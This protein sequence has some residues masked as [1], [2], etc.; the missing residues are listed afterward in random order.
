MCSVG[1]TQKKRRAATLRKRRTTS[2]QGMEV[3]DYKS[4]KKLSS[5]PSG[6]SDSAGWREPLS[7]GHAHATKRLQFVKHLA[8]IVVEEDG[9]PHTINLCRDC[10]Y[11][12]LA[13]SGESKVT[14][15]V[16]W[17]D[18]FLQNC[19]SVLRPRRCWAKHLLEAETKA[20]QFMTD[21]NRQ[22]ESPY[23]EELELLREG[24]DLQWRAPSMRQAF[25][26]GKAW[27]DR[28]F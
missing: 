13:A 27:A 4:L 23:K 25:Q 10:Y 28:Y 16:F 24:N 15:A 11:C 1:P 17:S 7:L 26:A 6:V 14:N 20:V 19:W 2:C 3:D 5:V 12:M 8:T 18:G 9:K 22:N 21:S